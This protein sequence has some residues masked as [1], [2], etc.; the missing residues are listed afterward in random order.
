[1]LWITKESLKVSLNSNHRFQSSKGL[2]V[3]T[4]KPTGKMKDQQKI[5]RSIWIPLIGEVCVYKTTLIPPHFFIK[6]AAPSHKNEWLCICVRGIAFSSVI[7]FF[8]LLFL[9]Y[10]DDMVMLF[11]WVFLAA[12]R[13]FGMKI[14]HSCRVLLTQ[15]AIT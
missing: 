11:F 12:T 6:V 13:A 14:H 3:W 2:K 10:S 8:R 4:G 5:Q 9:N 1:M 7:T 15:I